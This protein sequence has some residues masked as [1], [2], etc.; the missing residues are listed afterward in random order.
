MVFDFK[1]QMKIG[2][3]GEREFVSKYPQINPVKPDHR[4]FDFDSDIGSI[5]LKT[6]NYEMSKTPNFYFEQISDLK[7]KKLGGPWRASKDSVDH[8]VYFYVRDMTFFWFN[9]QNL[10]KFLDKYILDKSFKMV[11]N[12]GWVSTGYCVPRAE[13]EHLLIKKEKF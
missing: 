11:K 4:I 7:S 12:K 9:P 8:F 3:I 13:V 2:D 5:E 6:D 10:T 1:E